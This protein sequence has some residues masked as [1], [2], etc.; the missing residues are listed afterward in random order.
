MSELPL[1]SRLPAI[2]LPHCTFLP[3]GLLPLYIFEPRYRAM[4]RHAL[5]N[6]RIF[7]VAM[8]RSEDE[9]GW[10]NVAPIA[11]AGMIRACVRNPDGTSHLLLQGL[12]RARLTSWDPDSEFPLADVEWLETEVRDPELCKNVASQLVR[13]ACGLAA[14][15]G[16]LCQQLRDHLSTLPDPEPVADIIAYNFIRC[17]NRLQDIVECTVLDERLQMVD[18]ELR[19]LA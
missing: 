17:P 7:C 19:K 5:E 15:H 18:E 11:T 4:L 10:D 3:H 2:V 6:E 1:P 9:D 14:T 16:T 13:A 8:R 12:R